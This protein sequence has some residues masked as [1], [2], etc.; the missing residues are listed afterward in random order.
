MSTIGVNDQLYS[1]TVELARSQGKSVEQ[2]IAEVLQTAVGEVQSQSVTP[3]RKMRNGLPI[4]L[5]NGDALSI[6]PAAV[7]RSIEEDGF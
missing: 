2:F 4:M 5:V 7:R 1:R 3:R 6:D